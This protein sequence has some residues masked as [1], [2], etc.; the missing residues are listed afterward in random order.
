MTYLERIIK[1]LEEEYPDALCSLQYQ[2]DWQLLFAVRLLSDAREQN[3]YDRLR[4]EY[5]RLAGY[6]QQGDP[7]PYFPPRQAAR[8][9]QRILPGMSALDRMI[10]QNKRG[11][12]M[13]RSGDRQKVG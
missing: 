3:Q 8:Y 5:Y 11:T 13:W 7:K 12:I 1:A 2:V 4:E 9:T 6:R 10:R